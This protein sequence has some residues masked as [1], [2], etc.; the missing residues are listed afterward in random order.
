MCLWS[1][2]WPDWP[3][4]GPL[5]PYPLTS[6]SVHYA[7]RCPQVNKVN[8]H[9]FNNEQHVKGYMKNLVSQ[10][11]VRH[12]YHHH[13]GVT[14]HTFSLLQTVSPGRHS[15]CC[16]CLYKQKVT[17]VVWN[18]KRRASER[19]FNPAFCLTSAHLANRCRRWV[20]TL[21]N[22]LTSSLFKACWHLYSF[23]WGSGAGAHFT[24]PVIISVSNV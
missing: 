12:D 7:S 17:E 21:F 3:A 9:L 15:R 23:S 11:A 24:Q 14:M 20:Q 22:S 4:W 6:F 18:M 10:R 5:S 2:P 8:T 13:V 16:T 19:N 1:C